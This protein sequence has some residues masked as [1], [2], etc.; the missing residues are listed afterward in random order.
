MNPENCIPPGAA[1]TDEACEVSLQ[2]RLTE[3]HLGFSTPSCS[4]WEREDPCGP[5]EA[6]SA[7]VE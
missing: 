3:K 6:L 2:G 1:V 7:G 4:S 5:Q